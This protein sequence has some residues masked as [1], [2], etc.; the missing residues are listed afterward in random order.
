MLYARNAAGRLRSRPLPT[1][2]IRPP[3]SMSPR[4]F[5]SGERPP[6]VDLV[7][8]S[9]TKPAEKDGSNGEIMYGRLAGQQFVPDYNDLPTFPPRPRFDGFVNA[10]HPLSQTVVFDGCPDDPHRPSST[11]L[12]QTS[13]FQQPAADTFGAYDY[14][15]SGNPTRTA[16]EKHVAM[17]EGA[18]AG[19][20]FTSGMSALA[21]VTRLLK[22][23]DEILLCD[24]IYGGMYRLVD[25]VTRRQGIGINF[26][27]STDIDNVLNALTRRTRLVHV[28]TP[29]NPLMKIIDLEALSSAL[30]PR[31]VYLS[32]DATMM[33][34]L[35]MRP[36]D[37]GCDIVVHSGTKFFS[38]HADTMGGLVLTRDPEIEKQ[39]AFYQN[40]EGSALSPFD[41]WLF[42]RGIKTLGL[43]LER[44][45]A[46]A[47]K[48]AQY[49]ADHPLVKKVYWPGKELLGHKKSGIPDDQI[50]LHMEQTPLTDGGC[51]LISLET[52]D[53]EFSQR[54]VEACKILKITVS[55]GSVN[56]LVEMPTSMSHASIPS[57]LCQLPRDLV[58]I[59]CGIE[60]VR[61]IQADISQALATANAARTNENDAADAHCEVSEGVANHEKSSSEEVDGDAATFV[62]DGGRFD[63][64]FE[65]LPVTPK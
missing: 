30:R 48:I 11:P 9:P 54:F 38:G 21:A 10:L 15:R 27:D 25:R 64:K 58:R 28:E 50:R 8:D 12:Y 60:D 36:L 57:D 33:T 65:D 35:M 6:S 20:A 31:G 37:L 63:S 46:N 51:S 32:V 14:T 2:V 53:V 40:A 44:Q 16:L 39:V 22:A 26:V 5:S 24:D 23:G 45:N 56:S 29:S 13:T 62:S 61:D 41:C 55:F 42:L 3:W 59:S 18:R 7:D 43:R 17:L 1:I 4:D 47:C 19:F 49:L 34:P 52:G